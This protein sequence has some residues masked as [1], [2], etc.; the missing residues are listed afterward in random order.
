MDLKQMLIEMIEKLPELG[1]VTT[2]VGE[3]EDGKLLFSDDGTPQ[4]LT[5]DIEVL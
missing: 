1:S 4:H 5:I 3:S 2:K